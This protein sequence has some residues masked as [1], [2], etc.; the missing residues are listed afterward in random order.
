MAAAAL[1]ASLA[2]AARKESELRRLTAA[3]PGAYALEQ[4]VVSRDGQSARLIHSAPGEA[5][6]VPRAGAQ[7]EEI[8]RCR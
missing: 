5:F 1:L 6:E 8:A 4:K 7:F 3:L 2:G